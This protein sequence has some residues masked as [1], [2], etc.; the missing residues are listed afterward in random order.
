[1]IQANSDACC[2]AQDG[3]HL[4]AWPPSVPQPPVLAV[5]PQVSPGRAQTLHPLHQPPA[6]PPVP[7]HS[8]EKE[9]TVSFS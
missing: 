8:K 1:M 4:P 2:S 9:Q 6:P 7:G 5:V 3:T